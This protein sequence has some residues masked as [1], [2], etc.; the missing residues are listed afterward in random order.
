[1]HLRHVH[2]TWPHSMGL[3]RSC[4]AHAPCI[5]DLQMGVHSAK[6]LEIL[7]DVLAVYEGL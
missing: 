4:P 7:L 2:G 1:V 6:V 5:W 3:Q